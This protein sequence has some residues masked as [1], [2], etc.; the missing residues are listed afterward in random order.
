MSNWL[1]LQLFG[2][3]FVTFLATLYINIRKILEPKNCAAARRRDVY[4]AKCTVRVT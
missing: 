1:I 3:V 4:W 2:F